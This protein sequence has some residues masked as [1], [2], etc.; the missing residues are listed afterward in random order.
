MDGT[1][2]HAL[3]Q[4][5]RTSTRRMLTD[6]VWRGRFEQNRAIWERTQPVDEIRFCRVK[7]RPSESRRHSLACGERSGRCYSASR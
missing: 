1:F 5:C 4:L 7:R 3:L 2:S 6:I